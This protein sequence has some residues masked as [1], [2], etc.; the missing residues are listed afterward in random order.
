MQEKILSTLNIHKLTEAQYNKEVS[1][2]N[3]DEYA[4]YLTPDEEIDLSPYATIEDMNKKANSSDLT[5]HTGNKS[6]PHSVT[7]EQVGLGNVPNVTTND[8]TPTY[9]DT[10]TFATLT[11][12]EK[13]NVAFAK[14]KLAISRLITHI[15][16]SE[17]PH[18]VTKSQVGLGSV[19]NTS[20]ANK[21]VSTAQN[22]AI[23]NALSSAKSYTDTKVSSL[24][25]STTVD[26]KIGT[27][28]TSTTAHSDIR[29]LITALTSKL[30][31]F[32]DVDDETTDQLSEVLTLINNNKG[33]LESLTTSKINVSDIVN[34]LTTNSTGKVLSA[35]VGVTIKGL[36]DALQAELDSHT[37]AIAD[38]TGLQSALDGKA[39]SSHGTHVS[40]STTAPVMDGTANVGTAS[41]VARSDHKHPTDTSRA[42]KTDLDSHT[43][44]TTVHITATERTNWNSAKT[45]ADSTHA[46]SNAEKNQNA[47][48]NVKVGTT[49]VAADS[50]TDT[51]ELVAGTNITLTS[52]A[53]NDKVTITAKDTVYTHP[54]SGVT[55]GTYKSVT[56]NAQGHVT[57]GSNPTTLSGYGIT[58]AAAK[59]HSHDD[60]YYTESEIDSKVSALNSSISSKMDL[61]SAQTAS[62]VKTFSNG[63]NVGSAN[64]KY[65]ADAGALVISFS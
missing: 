17:N 34:N 46:P 43:I 31:N 61:T 20:D 65:D 50:A 55:A 52:D 18:N 4:L 24:P 21:P 27:H 48:S 1:N 8:Q 12:G 54:N 40:Y 28:N 29:E 37:H 60:M 47:F 10:T 14:I 6:N 15:D 30:N 53:T 7:K 5:S 25:T 11:S 49:T 64:L 39:A 35:S 2:G 32:L 16:N 26:N 22:T 63:I 45:H 62:G 56:V 33:T 51:L 57:G 9:S 13:L 19:D 36:I 58:D 44:N 42:A 23:N 59:S 41:T 38:V 3:A